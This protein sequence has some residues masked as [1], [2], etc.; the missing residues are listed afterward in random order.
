MM[1]MTTPRST[2]T[3]S[4]R[5]GL[6]CATAFRS[7][8][9]NV[10]RGIGAVIWSTVLEWPKEAIRC[11]LRLY[12]LDRRQRNTKR[13]PACLRGLI[14]IE[15]LKRFDRSVVPPFG[16][17]NRRKK[18]SRRKSG[19]E[20]GPFSFIAA[21]RV[22]QYFLGGSGRGFWICSIFFPVDSLCLAFS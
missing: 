5:D 13:D 8:D 15:G 22:F 21:V 3:E 19:P 10:E 20:A 7:S 2:S 14:G 18:R 12:R 6:A 16:V 11:S 17:D 9:G 1:T 4:R